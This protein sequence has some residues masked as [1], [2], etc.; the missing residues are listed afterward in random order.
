MEELNS[1][2]PKNLAESFGLAGLT[3][4][5]TSPGVTPRTTN[6]YHVTYTPGAKEIVLFFWGCNL[7]CRWCY[8][9]KN[10]HS[11]MLEEYI[12][13]PNEEPV[14]WASPPTKFLTFDEVMALFEG[15]E[16]KHVVME[17][18]EAAL[19]PLY[20]EIARELHRR[21]GTHNILLTNALQ[22][23]DDLSHTDSIE[24]SLKAMDDDLHIAHTGKSNKV[25]LEN[26][27]KLH[28]SGMKLIVESVF[29]PGLVDIEETER[30]AEFIASIDRTIPFIILP[31]IR[32]LGNSWQRPTP[33]DM[34][35]V[36]VVARKH[37][38]KVFCVR[39]DEKPIYE[40]I[41]L[42]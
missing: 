14:N 27:K 29:V 31:H 37:L 4:F 19:D 22:L 12:N 1:T 24:I 17:G 26:F 13:V 3:Q 8:R 28:E 7:A 41:K 9:Q 42:V 16:V 38:D 10:I 34:E 20:P 23:P 33:E 39:G 30:M 5:D 32:T 25:I 35:K 2:P 6:V 36:G 40:T 15:R 21:Y 11:L 18:A